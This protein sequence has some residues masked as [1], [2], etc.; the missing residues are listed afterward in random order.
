MIV[1]QIC[2]SHEGG[3]HWNWRFKRNLRGWEMEEFHNMVELLY[4]QE[5]HNDRSDVWN[6]ERVEMVS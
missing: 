3:V 1:K 6:A 2:R 4:G 5:I